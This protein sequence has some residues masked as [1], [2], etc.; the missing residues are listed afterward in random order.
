MTMETTQQKFDRWLSE[1]RGLMLKVVHSFASNPSDQD[2]LLQEIAMA[3][4]TSIRRFR[5]E[6]KESTWV[7]KVA[8]FTATTWSRG[9][10]KKQ[11]R[12][13]LANPEY[14]SNEHVRSSDPR[15]EWL[16]ETIRRLPV[17]D[18]ALLLSSLEGYSHEEIAK[19]TGLSATNVGVRL[20]RLKKKLAKLAT[21]QFDDVR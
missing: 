10:I 9:A 18:S 15:Q 20:H 5:N 2:D 3:L 12:R 17:I 14:L 16:L 4:W 7:Y 11:G 8:L 21:E 6:S 13:E 1:Y 19:L